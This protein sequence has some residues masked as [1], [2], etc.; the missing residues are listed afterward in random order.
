MTYDTIVLILTLNRTLGPVRNKTAGKIARVLLRDGILYY[1]SVNEDCSGS[2]LCRV[3][4]HVG[5]S[6]I[7]AVNLVLTLM[8]ATA[9]PG[10]QNITAQSACFAHLRSLHVANDGGS[11]QVG[12]FVRR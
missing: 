1:R 2:F 3:S 4:A 5:R 8:I 12:V 11:K 6:V 10:L 7:F 9:P